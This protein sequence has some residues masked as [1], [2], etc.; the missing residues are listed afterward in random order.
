MEGA[1]EADQAALLSRPAV[2]VVLQH[3]VG[4]LVA[5]ADLLCSTPLYLFC[6]ALAALALLLLSSALLP[7]LASAVAPSLAVRPK[8]HQRPAKLLGYVL[9]VA[10]T[11]TG[12]SGS[13][14]VQIGV[15]EQIQHG[16][17]CLEPF[18]PI[19]SAAVSSGFVDK[20]TDRTH[21]LTEPGL[22]C[23]T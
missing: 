13:R 1:L 17:P 19:L 14:V 4:M 3:L 20:A 23:S 5:W 2:E 7:S 21:H 10:Q 9:V 16:C 18:L 22:A 15:H 11:S 12:L 8:V 6:K